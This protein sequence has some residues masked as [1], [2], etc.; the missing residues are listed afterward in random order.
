MF[1]HKLEVH[2]NTMI[3]H[4]AHITHKPPRRSV[5]NL[6]S[7]TS[8]GSETRLYQIIHTIESVVLIVELARTRSKIGL[9]T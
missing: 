7:E 8:K 1:I 2:N 4:M 5:R 6:K 9:E 3:K